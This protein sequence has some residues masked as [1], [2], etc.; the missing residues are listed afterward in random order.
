MV[1]NLSSDEYDIQVG[2]IYSTILEIRIYLNYIK[3]LFF[4]N[5]HRINT[6][7][8]STP[9]FFLRLQRSFY[10]SIILHITK[11]LDPYRQGNNKNLTLETLYQK[12]INDDC[13]HKNSIFEEI[14]ETRLQIKN[15]SERRRK[16]IAHTDLATFDNQSSFS[17]TDLEKAFTSVLSIFNNIIS[18]SSVSTDKF[19][20]ET[21][22][23]ADML[24]MIKNADQLLLLVERGLYF[25]KLLKEH[26]EEDFSP[27]V[28]IRT[29]YKKRY[30]K[31]ESSKHLFEEG[32]P[33]SN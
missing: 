18:H 19:N 5:E 30:L 16:E 3:E 6:I 31:D 2:K 8:N 13:E 17:F 14:E 25:E 29:H 1:Q 33:P 20:N 22:Y 21:T 11:L 12:Y 24:V 23:A 7:N 28:P 27:F 10:E 26:S 15:L 9:S 32:K 4:F